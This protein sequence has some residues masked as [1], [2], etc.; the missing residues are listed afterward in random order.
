[1]PGDNIPAGFYI[2]DQC[3][4]D[5]E[6]FIACHDDG[7]C[8]E[9]RDAYIFAVEDCQREHLRRLTNAKVGLS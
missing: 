6:V 1:M 2:D 8:G 7:W 5:M 3:T 4:D 9:E